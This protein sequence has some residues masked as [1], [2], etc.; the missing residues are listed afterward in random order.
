MDAMLDEMSA[1]VNE[2]MGELAR[3]KT[4]LKQFINSDG[5]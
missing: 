5:L 3:K 4:E 1:F 2:Q